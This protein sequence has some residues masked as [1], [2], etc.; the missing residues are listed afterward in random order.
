[1]TITRTI[2]AIF[3]ISSQKLDGNRLRVLFEPV[4]R[5]I[6]YLF[7]LHTPR[8]ILPDIGCSWDHSVLW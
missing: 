1:M 5:L 2:Q 4:P 3:C 8:D 6:I 7:S